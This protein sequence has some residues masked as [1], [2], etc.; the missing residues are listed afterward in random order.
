[1]RITES[2]LRRIIR[3]EITR[4]LISERADSHVI[5]REG[6]AKVYK[7][8]T[9]DD[10][11]EY[12]YLLSSWFY[13]KPNESRWR[14]AAKK[15]WQTLDFQYRRSDPK[16][17]A[18]YGRS[19]AVEAELAASKGPP[20]PFGPNDKIKGDRFRAWVNDNK[21]S[22]IKFAL[23]GERDKTLDRTGIP[24]NNHM[25][26]VWAKFGAEY[27]RSQTPQEKKEEKKDWIGKGLEKVSDWWSGDEEETPANEDDIVYHKSVEEANLKI[28]E[29]GHE[30]N[31]KAGKTA[32][33]AQCTATGCAQFVNDTLGPQGGDAWH[34]HEHGNSGFDNSASSMADE[35]ASLFTAM[36]RKNGVIPLSKVKAIV[37]QAVP[38]KEKWSDL[39][40]GSVVGIFHYPSTYH[41]KAF[42]EGAT[43]RSWEGKPPFSGD[44]SETSD[45]GAFVTESGE[46]WD[47]SMLGKKIKFIPS[48]S[49]KSGKAFG[50]NTHL[51]FVGAKHRG[52]PIIFH[53]IPGDEGGRVLA[54]P[55][56][57]LGGNDQI[58][59]SKPKIGYL[60]YI[61]KSVV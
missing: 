19:K 12:K 43:G 49:L 58:A 53:N 5:R 48:D 40:L 41:A 54:S 24:D 59:W 8:V 18:A 31:V 14:Q 23:A 13:K 57:A 42:F 27:I 6:G 55:L 38:G 61:L 56:E 2:R 22:E 20:F 52:K 34:Q 37:R 28:P 1:M 33:I 44:G 21:S 39:P 50:M 35:L 32:M 4:D 15:S 9:D 17:A 51:G 47:P 29:G 16:V 7:G 46:P 45:G 60:N 36:N 11:Y 30:N 25:K 26:K 3:E 10:P